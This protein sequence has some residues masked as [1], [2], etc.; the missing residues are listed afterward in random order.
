MRLFRL[1]IAQLNASVRNAWHTASP[2]ILFACA[3]YTD[4]EQ[5]RTDDDAHAGIVRCANAFLCYVSAARTY[6]RAGMAHKYYA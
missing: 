4:Y 5:I 1:Q 2:A 6:G 3:V